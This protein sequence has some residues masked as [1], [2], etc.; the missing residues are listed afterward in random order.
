[1]NQLSRAVLL[2]L[3]SS[4]TVSCLG[5]H[6]P[7]APGQN[8]PQAPGQLGHMPGQ[9]SGY[10]MEQYLKNSIIYQ[11][12]G[13][14]P[15][16][17]LWLRTMAAAG[18]NTAYGCYKNKDRPVAEHTRSI[19]GSVGSVF[20]MDRLQYGFNK[21]LPKGFTLAPPFATAMRWFCYGMATTVLTSVLKRVFA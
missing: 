1:M 20:V 6:Q 7:T 8:L 12:L 19:A 3:I 10:M 15:E 18:C 9:P 2:G 13:M 16:D 11:I 14:L 4:I 21:M 5:M 17:S